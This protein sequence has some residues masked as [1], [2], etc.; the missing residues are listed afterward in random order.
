MLRNPCTIELPAKNVCYLNINDGNILLDYF[1]CFT[2]D[3]TG[4]NIG[5]KITCAISYIS[6]VADDPCY[7][8][9]D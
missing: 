1:L 5:N 8:T 9:K 4:K 3:S 7:S 2:I 6:K